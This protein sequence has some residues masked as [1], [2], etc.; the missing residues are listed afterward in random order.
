M[1]TRSLLKPWPII[2]VALCIIFFVYVRPVTV[3][4]ST[5]WLLRNE[6][7]L[8]NVPRPL[9]LGVD[10]P[11]TGR[12]FS[13]FGFEFDSPWTE[14]KWEKQYQSALVLHFSTGGII[15]VFAPVKNGSELDAMKQG[16]A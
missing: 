6:P 12:E 7:A 10:R 14:L 3:L 5:K 8:W 15:A 9:S 11:S 4:L 2:G 13:C 16:A 1:N